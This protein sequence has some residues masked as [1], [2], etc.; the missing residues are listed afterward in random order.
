MARVGA[1]EAPLNEVPMDKSLEQRLAETTIPLRELRLIF[2]DRMLSQL[3]GPPSESG[4]EVSH[5]PW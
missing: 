5:S 4:A 3:V 2:G 1:F